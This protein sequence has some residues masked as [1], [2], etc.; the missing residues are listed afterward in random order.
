[1][2]STETSFALSLRRAQV[3]KVLR[4][5]MLSFFGR[6]H[7]LSYDLATSPLWSRRAG[8]PAFH[9]PGRDHIPFQGG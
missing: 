2:Q 9:Q 1:M 8:A 5:T 3:G 6:V 4:P 7:F